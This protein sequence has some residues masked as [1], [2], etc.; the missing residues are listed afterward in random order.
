MSLKIDNSD[1]ETDNL[2]VVGKYLVHLTEVDELCQV[3]IITFQ[4]AV[5]IS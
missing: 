3:N 4:Q 1:R 5:T 2:K